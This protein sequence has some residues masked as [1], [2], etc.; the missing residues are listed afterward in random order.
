[1]KDPLNLPRPPQKAPFFD[2]TIVPEPT[3]SRVTPHPDARGLDTRVIEVSAVYGNVFIDAQPV[4]LAAVGIAPG[5]WFELTVRDQKFRVRHGTDFTSVKKGEWVVFPNADGFYWLARNYG[6]AAAT[7]TLKL[8][9]TIT[10][11]P[12][13]DP[14]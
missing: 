5:T 6:D 9:D 11:R 2:A 1:M 7:A 8:G 14:K 4:D 12:Y 10:L 3:A 13:D